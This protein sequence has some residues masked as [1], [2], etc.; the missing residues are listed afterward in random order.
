MDLD[1]KVRLACADG[2]SKRAAHHFNISRDTVAKAVAFS[3]PPG[4]RRKSRSIGRNWTGIVLCIASRITPPS[5]NMIAC[6]RIMACVFPLSLKRCIVGEGGEGR[7]ALL[8][9]VLGAENDMVARVVALVVWQ[10]VQRR[11]LGL[12]KRGRTRQ[13]SA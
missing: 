13:A 8:F 2:M 4:Y 12:G 6:A 1:R 11:E 5:G 9:D 7:R 10:I 3:V